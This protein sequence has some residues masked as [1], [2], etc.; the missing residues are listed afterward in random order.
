MYQAFC[1]ALYICKLIWL[2]EV[3]RIKC[4]AQDSR[5][6]SNNGDDEEIDDDSLGQIPSVRPL[7]GRIMVCKVSGRRW[8][9]GQGLGGGR[10]RNIR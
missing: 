1:Q 4:L 6:G 5:N 9:E 2:N 7:M 3:M 8:K 10:K